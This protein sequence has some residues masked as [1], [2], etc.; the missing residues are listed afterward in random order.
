MAVDGGQ[1]TADDKAADRYCNFFG[2]LPRVQGAH[3]A[4]KMAIGEGGQSGWERGCG[5]RRSVCQLR[6]L[7]ALV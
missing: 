1:M 4:L 6:G 2:S 3:A 5:E 7:D